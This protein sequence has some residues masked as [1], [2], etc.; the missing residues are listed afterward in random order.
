MVRSARRC[1]HAGGRRPSI[2]FYPSLVYHSRALN[3]VERANLRTVRDLIHY[4]LARLRR[5]R[6]VGSKTRREL[7]ECMEKSHRPAFPE[8]A[9]EPKQ[10]PV[11]EAEAPAGAD[12]A[13]SIDALA[14]TARPRCAHQRREGQRPGCRKTACWDWRKNPPVDLPL[15]MTPTPGRARARSHAAC[16]S[17]PPRSARPLPVPASAG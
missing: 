17:T 16:R 5:L 3:A 12:E 6:G 13:P 9:V 8:A 2:P 14:A 4:P 15:G 11:E 10:L 1:H 7:A